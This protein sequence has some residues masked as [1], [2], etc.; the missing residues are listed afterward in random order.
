MARPPVTH[1]DPQ[2][3]ARDPYPAL[4]AMRANAPITYVPELDAILLTRRD[5]IHV[6]E[7]RTD[8]FSSDQ[9]G[10]L[11]TVLMGQ[12]M[13]RKDGA[14]HMAERKAL[15]PAFSPRT[16]AEHWKPMFIEAT[17][18]I[19]ERLGPKG[20]AD[21][22]RDFAMP[23]SAEALKA[24]TGLAT[25]TAEEMDGSSQGMI[26][27]CANYAGDTAVEA[28]CHAATALIDA[29]IDRQFAAPP[30][31][32]ALDVAKG[33]EHG[34]GEHPRQYQAG[35]LG[36]AERASGC[37]S[38]HRLGAFAAPRATG[39]DPRRGGQLA[40]GVCRIRAP[41]QP[42]SACRRAG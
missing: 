30:E 41:S 13:M 28:R 34:D 7:K 27:G 10:G 33:G 5:D 9:P 2:A 21:L 29:H 42:P 4:A 23:V 15:F 14:A 8:V 20:D 11:M 3:F 16:V 1:I 38:G 39:N 12:N 17:A 37:D 19:L 26:D 35:D 22:V 31:K 36:R 24:I 32:S 18:R 25:M 6:Q 40:T